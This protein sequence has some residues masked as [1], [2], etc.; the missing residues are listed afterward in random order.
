MCGYKFM[1]RHMDGGQSQVGLIPVHLSK[2]IVHGFLKA[3]FDF[4]HHAR[5]NILAI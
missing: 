2:M 1:F 4:L 3:F 5:E